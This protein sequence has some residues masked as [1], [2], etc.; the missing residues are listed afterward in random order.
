MLYRKHHEAKTSAEKVGYYSILKNESLGAVDQT[1]NAFS[2]EFYPIGR[3]PL[4]PDN[5]LIVV[6]ISSENLAIKVLHILDDVRYIL[7]S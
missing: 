1:S 5:H 7:T 2:Y 4:S 3:L 6:Q